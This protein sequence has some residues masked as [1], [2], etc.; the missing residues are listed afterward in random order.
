[1]SL[2]RDGMLSDPAILPGDTSAQEAARHLT[3]PDVRALLVVDG[4]GV[5]LGLVTHDSLVEHVLAEG[6]D[7]RSTDVSVAVV[8]P[9][10]VLDADQ[11][12]DDGYRLLEEAE[13]ERAPVVEQGRLVGVVSRSV[14]QRR[15]AEEEPPPDDDVADPG[16]S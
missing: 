10:L 5:L 7:P 15:L 16:Y 12:L 14:V 1:M 6:L 9:P 13:L 4:E 3:R 8:R 11:L 2:V